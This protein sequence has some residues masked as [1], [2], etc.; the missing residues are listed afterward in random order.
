MRATATQPLLYRAADLAPAVLNNSPF[1]VCAVGYAIIG[2]VLKVGGKV[3]LGFE[4]VHER[5]RK[6]LAFNHAPVDFFVDMLARS[7]FARPEQGPML[8]GVHGKHIPDVGPQSA[9][10]PA[11][12]RAI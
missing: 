10:R 1:E 11:Q 2:D 4:A 8:D 3:F 7:V 12:I 9:E 6:A 5:F